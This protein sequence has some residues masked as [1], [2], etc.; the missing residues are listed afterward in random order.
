MNIINF[1][2]GYFMRLAIFLLLIA[3]L[4]DGCGFGR[5]RG[6]HRGRVDMT[7]YK[8]HVQSVIMDVRGENIYKI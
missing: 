5:G 4:L 3:I 7:N 2:K 8:M 1:N 6:R